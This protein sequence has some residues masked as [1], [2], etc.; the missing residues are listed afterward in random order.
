[1][2]KVRA[3]FSSSRQSIT[4][5]KQQKDLKVREGELHWVRHKAPAAKSIQCKGMPPGL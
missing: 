1:M 2:A 5:Y 3:A 4:L